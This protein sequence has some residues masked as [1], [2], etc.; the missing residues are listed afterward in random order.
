MLWKPYKTFYRHITKQ[1]Y[2]TG[3]LLLIAAKKEASWL[4]GDVSPATHNLKKLD[5][6][7]NLFDKRAAKRM[8]YASAVF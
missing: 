7:I 8:M 4:F 3:L 6:W 1:R 5:G 2:L